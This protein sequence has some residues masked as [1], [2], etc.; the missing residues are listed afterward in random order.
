MVKPVSINHGDHA[1]A[2]TPQSTQPAFLSDAARLTAAQL[3]I[4]RALP[5]PCAGIR[6]ASRKHYDGARWCTLVPDFVRPA[7]A[8]GIC[9]GQQNGTSERT[10]L[11]RH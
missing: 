8:N 3:A 7:G 2:T 1:P 10:R 4:A 11:R 5:L 6:A 9:A